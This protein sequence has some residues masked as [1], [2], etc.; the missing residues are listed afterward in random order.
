MDNI[1]ESNDSLFHSITHITPSNFLTKPVETTLNIENNINI[2]KTPTNKIALL[3]ILDQLNS[4]KAGIPLSNTLDQL[5]SQKG[6]VSL[7]NIL[8]KLISQKGEDS[9]SNTSDKL[10]SQ[11]EEVP[12]FNTLDQLSYQKGDIPIAII[13]SNKYNY[14]SPVFFP[15]PLDKNRSERI[16]NKI[17]M[18]NDKIYLITPDSQINYEDLTK[19][20][21]INYLSNLTSTNVSQ[22]LEF[23][24]LLSVCPQRYIDSY[25]LTPMKWQ[26]AGT[27]IAVKKAL[28][29]NAAINIGGGF[30]QAKRSR[31][32]YGC[33][34]A[35]IPT[36][37]EKHCSDKTVAIINLDA[38]QGSGLIDYVTRTTNK[39]Y[40]LNIYNENVY[41]YDKYN[42]DTV[43]KDIKIND[44]VNFDKILNVSLDGGRMEHTLFGK[45]DIFNVTVDKIDPWCLA[46]KI[47]S[48][49]ICNHDYIRKLNIIGLFLNKVKPDIVIYNAS[50]TPYYLDKR[51]CMDVTKE[52]IIIRDLYV[53]HEVVVR[54]IPI[55]MTISQGYAPDE[56]DIIAESIQ[57]II[58]FYPKF[59]K[60][61]DISD[62]INRIDKFL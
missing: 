26:V 58:K 47:Y 49:K 12:L 13:Y 1:I 19:V 11:K 40:L 17:D 38:H 48:R 29:I 39:V 5:I 57:E 45:K 33:I 4:K 52:G 42:N 30:H 31:G 28:D 7:S 46:E 14:Y 34:Y 32:Q 53:W 60:N 54:K 35:D 56:D 8:D 37:I 10:N 36:A 44:T 22:I 9:I 50:C 51:G 18:K 20:H 43:T 21:T 59:V 41:P 2:I 25:I 6:E 62:F 23:P 3:D 61:E 24:L 27:C 16:F 55:A 15:H